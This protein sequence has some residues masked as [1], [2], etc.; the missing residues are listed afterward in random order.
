MSRC[1]PHQSNKCLYEALREKVS[2]LGELHEILLKFHILKVEF[3]HEKI[4]FFGLDFFLSRYGCVAFEN[5]LYIELI[6][7]LVGLAR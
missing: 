7:M 3:L 1:R 4:I 2:L 5:E 6:A